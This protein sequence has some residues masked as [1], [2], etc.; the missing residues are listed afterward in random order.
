MQILP[1]F[2]ALHRALKIDTVHPISMAKK[3]N[4]FDQIIPLLAI[5]TIV[6]LLI[7]IYISYLKTAGMQ[8]NIIIPGG[9]T[10][11]GK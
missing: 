5:G 9:T 10:Y 11:L 8:P 7:L 3:T 2:Y 4:E 6:I 1:H